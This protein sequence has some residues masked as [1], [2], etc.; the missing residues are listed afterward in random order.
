MGDEFQMG[1]LDP[2]NVSDDLG[3]EPGSA[4]DSAMRAAEHSMQDLDESAWD[5]P[6][7]KPP[8]E[9]AGGAEEKP[10]PEAKPPAEKPALTGDLA[11]DLKQMG[12]DSP[13][14]VADYIQ[15]SQEVN[16]RFKMLMD[17]AG[18]QFKGQTP[19]EWMDELETAILEDR[20]Q[21]QT[22]SQDQNRPAQFQRQQAPGTLDEL[23]TK[24][25]QPLPDGT[26]LEFSEGLK[27]WYRDLMGA[28][29]QATVQA[30]QEQLGAFNT[31]TKL[32]QYRSWYDQAKAQAGDEP[33]PSFREAFNLLEL[34]PELA[35]RAMER[36]Q[37]FRDVD[38]N[39][40]TLAAQRWRG[41][42][43]PVGLTKGEQ[44]Q[45][46]REAKKVAALKKLAK[47]SIM[48]KARA[49]P[50]DEMADLADQLEKIPFNRW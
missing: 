44:A 50:S 15:M 6:D 39:P 30:V 1:Q 31:Q 32:F 12:F 16:E 22:S 46:D 19:T 36:F 5:R 43:S 37:V 3:V 38:Y 25:S 26:S 4:N 49:K 34:N 10:V 28:T 23:F 9:E 17:A 41:M 40:V 8:A 11:E 18:M 27:G 7:S 21:R 24:Y 2:T 29:V 35:Q 14:E 33:F 20:R 13:Q 48:P 47:P 42:K 45:R